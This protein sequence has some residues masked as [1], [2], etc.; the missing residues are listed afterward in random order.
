MTNRPNGTLYVGVTSDLR[1][2][3][4]EHRAG[5]VE[6][7]TARYELKLLVFCEAHPTMLAAIQREK[8]IKQ[9]RRAWKI[10]LIEAL[11]PEWQDLYGSLN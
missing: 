1:R 2:R 9:W 5:F 8:N 11:N 10:R 7:F 4:C 6:G 3:A